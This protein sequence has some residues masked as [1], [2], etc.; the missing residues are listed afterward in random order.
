MKST[1]AKQAGKSTKGRN[2]RN[3][4][5]KGK[6]TMKVCFQPEKKPP[7]I[8]NN[9]A[10]AKVATLDNDASSV[11]SNH[12]SRSNNSEGSN[13]SYAR[14]VKNTNTS[15]DSTPPM[16]LEG[17]FAETLERT[18]GITTM[19]NSDGNWTVVPPNKSPP[20]NTDKRNR[21]STPARQKKTDTTTTK[22]ARKVGSPM[23][24]DNPNHTIHPNVA[25]EKKPEKPKPTLPTA[26]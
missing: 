14:A 15:T 19:Q 5:N 21:E 20:R 4:P 3:K 12:S 6:A 24:R 13:N 25:T 7:Q 26:A 1:M 23:E 10:N 17:K 18:E 8:S 22:A 16:N 11:A 2:Q 9:S